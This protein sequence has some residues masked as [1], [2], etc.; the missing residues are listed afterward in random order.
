MNEKRIR[1][2]EPLRDREDLVLR[3]GPEDARVGVI[4]WGSTV[5]VLREVLDVMTEK[6]RTFKVLAPCVLYPLPTAIVQRFVDSVDRLLVIEMSHLGQFYRYLRM[7]VDF[8]RD[9]VKAY[10]RS[11]GRVFDVREVMEQVEG[12]F[13]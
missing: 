13:P 8:P 1:K 6:G 12:V 2:L 11:G 10:H 7:H 4:S 5:S 9:G 3:Y